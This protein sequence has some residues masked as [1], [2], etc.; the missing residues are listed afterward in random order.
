MTHVSVR[1]FSTSIIIKRFNPQNFPDIQ[2]KKKEEKRRKKKIY[3]KSAGV[4]KKPS[5]KVKNFLRP[6]PSP[7]AC[8]QK[9]VSL[10]LVRNSMLLG[11]NRH[12]KRQLYWLGIQCFR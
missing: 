2:N 5:N 12:Y 9:N 3:S 8:G 7:A 10:Q 6:A 4:D 1:K 11:K